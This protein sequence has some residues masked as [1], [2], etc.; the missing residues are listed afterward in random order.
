MSQSKIHILVIDD[1]RNIRK[2]LKMIL[3]AAGYGE[4]NRR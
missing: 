2:N 4:R 1:S 3:E